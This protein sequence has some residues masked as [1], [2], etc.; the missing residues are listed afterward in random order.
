MFILVRNTSRP[1][2]TEERGGVLYLT[3]FSWTQNWA[4]GVLLIIITFWLFVFWRNI[5]ASLFVRSLVRC[6]FIRC[7]HEFLGNPVWCMATQELLTIF[8]CVYMKPD[9]VHAA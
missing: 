2:Q 5:Q 1:A 6:Q 3:F 7:T 4:G 8:L 9:L